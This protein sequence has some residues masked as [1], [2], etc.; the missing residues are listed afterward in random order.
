MGGY[1]NPSVR[2]IML[3]VRKVFK[4]FR[5][6][7]LYAFILAIGLTLAIH[8]QLSEAKSLD[9]KAKTAIIVDADTGKVLFEKDADKA[10]PPASMTKMMTEYIVL[11]QINKGDLSWDTTT[12][13]S[14]YAYN[15]S[16]NN[17]FS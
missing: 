6:K 1:G 8:P 5:N 3:E 13:I 12:E 17:A 15:I 9:T 14:D 7:S 2:C 4:I 16:A 10:L 11:E